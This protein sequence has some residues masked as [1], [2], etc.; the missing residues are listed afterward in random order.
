MWIVIVLYSALLYSIGRIVLFIAGKKM[1]ETFKCPECKHRTVYNRRLFGFFQVI[2][3]VKCGTK[4][5]FSW[6]HE[7]DQW[8]PVPEVSGGHP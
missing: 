4:T 5:L 3:C 1:T 6:N 8:K 2:T 7:H